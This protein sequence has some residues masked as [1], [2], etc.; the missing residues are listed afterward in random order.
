MRRLFGELTEVSAEDRYSQMMQIATASEP[1]F[2]RLAR[3][4]DGSD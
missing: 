2:Q 1:H 4:P 3:I